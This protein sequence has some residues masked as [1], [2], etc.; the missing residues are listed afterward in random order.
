VSAQNAVLN[1]AL[2]IDPRLNL[3]A[4]L[5]VARELH[6]SLTL[7]QGVVADES[8]ISL[9]AKLLER[10]AA[11]CANGLDNSMDPRVQ[12]AWSTFSDVL[13]TLTLYHPRW[14]ARNGASTI[15]VLL[16]RLMYSSLTIGSDV[17][18]SSNR[19]HVS[20]LE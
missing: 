12:N 5:R 13:T 19:T 17:S 15:A 3:A 2:S 7:T 1:Q 11:A 16:N 8:E 18:L 6:A 20:C 4:C 14:M 10:S 9:F